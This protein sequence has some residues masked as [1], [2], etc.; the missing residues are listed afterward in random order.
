MIWTATIRNPWPG[1]SILCLTFMTAQLLTAGK[2][3]E[4]KGEYLTGRRA[5]LPQ[6]AEGHVALLL[7]GFTYQSRFAVEAWAGRFRK[8]FDND[9]RVTFLRD[10]HDWRYG[11]H[12]KWFIDSGMRRGTSKADYEHVITVYGGTDAWKQRLGVQN[13]DTAY[14]VILDRE[15]NMVWQHAGPS[16]R[17]NTNVSPMRSANCLPLNEA[18]AADAVVC[19]G[20]IAGTIALTVSMALESSRSWVRRPSSAP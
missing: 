8:D 10:P 16:K 5:V 11:A 14:L 19:H 2:L 1:F 9:P 6:D 17:P 13:A 3:P 12:G 4:L 7:F 18:L 20:D 15:G